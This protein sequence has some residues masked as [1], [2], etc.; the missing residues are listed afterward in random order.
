L[1][2]AFASAQFT[3]SEDNK[4][5]ALNGREFS[6]EIALPIGAPLNY[7]YVAKEGDKEL[8]KGE[9]A[10][11]DEN[12][13]QAT[14]MSVDGLIFES[15]GAHTIVVDFMAVNT[16]VSAGTTEI[17]IRSINGWLTLVP[18]IL[19]LLVAFFTN[20]VLIALSFGIFMSA[21]I[22]EG[23]NVFVAFLRTFDT[24]VIKAL[25][26]RDHIKIVVFSWGLSGL[27]ALIVKSG[28]AKGLAISIG[29]IVK[30]RYS[31]Q[32]ATLALGIIIF[33]DDYASALIVGHNMRLVTDTVMLSHEKLAFIV[34]A[35]SAG[36]ASLVP[37]SSWIG[38]E[39]GL[40][41]ENLP[42][43]FGVY[44]T[45]DEPWG[46]LGVFIASVPTRFYPLFILLVIVV[47]VVFRREFG[48]MLTSERRALNEG[49]LVPTND[50]L[51]Q[52]V[53]NE[54]VEDED[55]T[56]VSKGHQN[57]RIIN[58][59]VPLLIMIISVI[60]GLF[61]SGYYSITAT[62]E[63]AE[64]PWDLSVTNLAGNGNSY[65]AL[66]WS[67]VG[68]LLVTMFMYS[69]VTKAM[70]IRE[71]MI[72]FVNGVK[73]ITEALL[74]LTLAWGISSAFKA[75]GVPDF[76]VGGLGDSLSSALLPSI[77]FLLSCLISFATG[78][79]WGTMSI[80]FPLALPLAANYVKVA[81]DEH[82]MIAVVSSILTGSI[83][84][85]QCSPI[86]DTSI[87]SALSSK[88]SVVR[89]V[90]TQLPYALLAAFF[91]FVAYFPGAAGLYPAWINLFIFGGLLSAA[92]FFIASKVEST[93]NRF[94]EKLF[95]K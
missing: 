7:T 35:T 4:K 65:D 16:T 43:D 33:F 18:V 42:K 66:I 56:H 10:G 14:K 92:F 82:I 15:M 73:D 31:A 17:S 21:S 44:A 45:G 77:V 80:M 13:E 84:G 63:T 26:D 49:L 2:A 51:Y 9:V 88:I 67:S 47:S 74:V 62:P 36:P 87:L 38:F 37:I 20:Q 75:L 5:V 25:A 50:S 89:H 3:A 70:T 93:E 24:Y 57:P 85:D 22:I 55:T 68:T 61:I 79:S 19:T 72:A 46:A 12:G 83:F 90:E 81:A 95:F 59:L 78:T 8:A 32:V 53:H 30:T 86:S 41:S 76:I 27:V 58:A 60:V 39:L 64:E 23:G 54:A 52:E 94:T 6:L 40:I 28:G 69:V 71:S 48:P 1:L 11:V 29:R 91:A 34:H